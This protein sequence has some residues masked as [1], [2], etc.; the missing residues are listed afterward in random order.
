MTELQAQELV[1]I[2]LQNTLD[3]RIIM[4]EEFWV[5]L[6]DSRP[7]Y[8]LATTAA[9]VEAS[10]V[11]SGCAGPVPGG[12]VA[13][14]T[15]AARPRAAPGCAPPSDTRAGAPPPACKRSARRAPPATQP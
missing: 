2:R 5:D 4:D 15:S 6:H 9:D 13:S 11:C 12:G 8:R 3:A 14:A 7:S 1:L 10:G